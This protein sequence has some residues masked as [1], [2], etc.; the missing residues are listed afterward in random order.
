M[1]TN[2]VLKKLNIL[3]NTM[4]DLLIHR[5]EFSVFKNVYIISTESLSSG[6]KTNDF[7]LKYFS[8][9][10]FKSNKDSL[11]DSIKNFVPSINQVEVKNYKDL[12]NK[13]FNGYTIVLYK[14]E[15]FAFE[16]RAILDRG[17]SEPKSEPTI[18]GPKDSFTENYNIN[19]GLIRKRIKSDNLSLIENIVG[20]YSMS[21]V[22]VMYLCDTADQEVVNN[23]IKK[24]KEIN[25]D[26][27][28]DAEYIK[29]LISKDYKSAF[30]TIIS[31]EKPD[32]VC[33]Q[34]LE[35]KIIITV[36][37]SP[38]VLII[39]TFLIDFFQYSED[40]YHTPFY[41][42]FIRIVRVMAF[43]LA[44]LTPAL[45]L[46]LTTYNQE[47]LPTSLLVNFAIQRDA[48]PFPAFIEALFL[49]IP[50][51]I[52]FEGDA[53]TPAGR[54]TSLSILGALILGEAA[55]SA[56]LISP[57]MIIVV[58]ISAISSLL[59]VY[60]DLQGAITFW[61]YLLMI[62]SGLFGILGL[63]IGCFLLLANL[64]TIKSFGKPYLLP[65]SPFYKN[66]QSNALT[67]KNIKNIKYRKRYLSSTNL[68]KNRSK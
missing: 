63:I 37:N 62:L 26:G 44:V 49:L 12:L 35:G 40:Y 14:S 52:L 60:Y 42:S 2:E 38:T 32:D 67:R 61:K 11:K 46:S 9:R 68:V 6:D 30:P 28:L 51:E 27:I 36:E 55:V 18:K 1:N 41:A 58:S 4:P 56:G 19:I 3:K 43:I 66:E 7:V 10:S 15:G 48:V 16:T 13:L 24:I 25:I 33:K 50:F 8:N 64:C 21:K 20:K 54:S 5:V 22:G 65:F 39:P 59:F 45:Y 31:T 34:L 57:I 47:I 23:V 17:V 29:E 53:R